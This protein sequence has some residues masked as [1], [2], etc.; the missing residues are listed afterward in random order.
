[1]AKKPTYNEF[2]SGVFERLG[3]EGYFMDGELS[4]READRYWKSEYR[5]RYSNKTT[6]LR[7]NVRRIGVAAKGG[8]NG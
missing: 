8:S 2:I 6:S 7:S 4:S 5:R 1:M 3:P